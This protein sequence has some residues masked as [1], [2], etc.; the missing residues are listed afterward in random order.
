MSV[1]SKQ[2]EVVPEVEQDSRTE[3]DIEIETKQE[4]EQ[5]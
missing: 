4:E 2:L 3:D 5:I 1:Q